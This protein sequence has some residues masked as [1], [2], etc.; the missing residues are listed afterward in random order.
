MRAYL[1]QIAEG[2]TLSASDAEAAVMSIMRG[3]ASPAE[4]AGFLV[5][6]RSRGETTDELEGCARAMRACMVQVDLDDEHAVDLCGTGGDGTGTFNVSTTASFVVAGAGVTVA[7]HG[8]RSVSSASGSADVLES[9]GVHTALAAPAV[10]ECLKKAGIGFL[11]APVFHPAMRHVM[12]VRKLLGVRTMFN[13]MGPICNPARVTRQLIGVFDAEIGRKMARILHRLGAEHV[14]IAHAD[15]GL[16]EISTTGPTRLFEIRAASSE[17]SESSVDPVSLGFQR[18][19]LSDLA[20]AGVEENARI[21]RDVLGGSGGPHRD[22]VILNA[23]FA[24]LASGRF[25]D[26]EACLEAAATSIDSGAALERL[27][28]LIDTTNSLVPA[29]TNPA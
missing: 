9:L 19:K 22:I 23:A 12:P 18:V 7:K 24:L 8:N 13:V 27:G 1:R 6:M 28:A 11:F 14:I 3:E 21:L 15:D 4:I 29:D 5:G 10:E 16:D 20:G 17:V 25:D 26:L 2:G